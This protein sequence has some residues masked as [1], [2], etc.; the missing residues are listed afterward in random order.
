MSGE[1]DETQSQFAILKSRSF[2]P[3]FVTQ[4]IGAFNDN[5]VRNGIAILITYDLAVRF[6][7]DAALFVQAGLA[8]FMLPYFLFSAIA[9]QLADKYDKATVARWVKLFELAAM[10]F[11]A[12]SLWLEN[13]IMHLIVLFLA[14]TTAAFFG[15]L[16]Y[17]VLPQYLRR[18]QLIGGNALI[19][20]GTFVTILLGT[21]FGGFL[22]LDNAFGR[23]FLAIT[24]VVLAVIAWICAFLMPPAPGD[25]SITFDWNIPRATKKLLSYAR[26]RE[27]V[28]W[29]VIGASWFWFLGAAVMAQLPVFTRDVLLAN[30]AVANAFIGLFTIGIGAGSLL[31]NALLKG[32][33]SPR[34]VPIASIMMTV[35]LLDLYFAAGDAHAVMAGQTDAGVAAFFSHWQGWRVGLDLFF[36]A[37]FGGLYAVPLNA[38]MQHRSVPSRRSRVIAANNVMNAIFMICSAIAGAVLLKVM[39]AQAFFLLLGL[40]NAVA[41]VFV[42]HLLTQE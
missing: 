30:D 5:A 37:F 18:D 1:T 39:S 15:P 19:E 33:V 28:F 6:H 20:L 17:G 35:F 4:A 41:S 10:I 25:R 34:Y 24:I 31:T 8:L 32:E 22:V 23:G 27:D 2:L 42:A 9:G 14:G 21:L 16:K 38:I 13:P 40:C 7:F 11:G 29:S 3:L 36:V 12:L 26:E